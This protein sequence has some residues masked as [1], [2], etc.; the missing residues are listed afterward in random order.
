MP[1]K[2][3][4]VGLPNVGKSTL[5]N[6]LTQSQVASENYPFCTIQPN[7][8]L[9]QIQDDE[10]DTL[11][12]L[13][14]GSPRVVPASVMI[15]DIAGLVKGASEGE[16]LG[17]QFLAQIREV[18]ALI[19]VVRCFDDPLITH[20]H[21]R[22]DPI[23][24][25]EVVNFEFMCADLNAVEQAIIKKTKRLKHND[26]DVRSA[27]SLYQ[28][29]KDHLERSRSAATFVDSDTQQSVSHLAELHLLSAKKQLYVCN[30]SEEN[31]PQDQS[32]TQAVSSY[33][34]EHGGMVMSLC[35]Q[36]E[37]EI[38]QLDEKEERAEILATLGL[39]KSGLDQL[40][41][42]A[43]KLLN[44]FDY[45]TAGPKEVRAWTIPYGITAKD[46]AGKIHSDMSRGFICAEVYTV[47]D[48]SRHKTKHALKEA[49]LI[50]TEGQDYVVQRG[51][52]M[53]FRFNV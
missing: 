37:S 50:R 10:L 1:L 49:G 34:H 22:C 41:E 48:L 14:P 6:A 5:F 15:T 33:A 52:V 7:T 20:V 13:T 42:Q 28:K 18:D 3:G 9:A 32:F 45:Y 31:S 11:V 25:I 39:Q 35:A 30:T 46:A 26:P 2:C 53:E 36:L 47:S 40:T 29:L 27:L 43:A 8:A 51:D 12:R 19:H 17:N 24:D 23:A 4:I 38:N 44:V 21:S 16:G